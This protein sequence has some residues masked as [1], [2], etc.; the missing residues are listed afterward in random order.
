MNG[1]SSGSGNIVKFI[2]P[3]MQKKVESMRVTEETSPG[4]F[5]ILDTCADVAEKVTDKCDC[6]YEFVRCVCSSLKQ[7]NNY[8]R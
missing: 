8:Y 4:F 2:K 1:K 7:V 3:A 6:G 5:E